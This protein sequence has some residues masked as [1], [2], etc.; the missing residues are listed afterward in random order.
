MGEKDTG[1]KR[2]VEDPAIVN[3]ARELTAALENR[4]GGMIVFL[5]PGLPID[6]APG[7][8]IESS[9]NAGIDSSTN[10]KKPRRR[11]LRRRGK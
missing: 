11:F 5:R 9:A 2:G 3:L 6:N 10:V 7:T 1:K 8:Q 4:P